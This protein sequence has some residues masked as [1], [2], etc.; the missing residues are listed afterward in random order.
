M[1]LHK[2]GNNFKLNVSKTADN[3]VV[4]KVKILGEFRDLFT[5]VLHRIIFRKF[6]E[7]VAQKREKH[8]F[9]LFWE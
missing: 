9:L 7:A 1:A 2:F 8:G 6:I 5:E 3:Q 4:N